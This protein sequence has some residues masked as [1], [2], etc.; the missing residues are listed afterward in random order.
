MF[1]VNS[2]SGRC[3]DVDGAPGTGNGARLQLWDCEFSGGPN[4]SPTDQKWGVRR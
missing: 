2:V 3:I 1:I 4:N